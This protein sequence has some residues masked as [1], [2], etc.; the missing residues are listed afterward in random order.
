MT[1]DVQ[2]SS[3]FLL[4]AFGSRAH[5]LLEYTKPMIDGI[6]LNRAHA[7]YLP[8]V[9]KEESGEDKADPSGAVET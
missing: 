7:D 6:A 1:I 8:E 3:T 9:L 4:D 2:K 5:A